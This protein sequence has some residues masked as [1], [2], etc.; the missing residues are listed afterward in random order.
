MLLSPPNMPFCLLFPIVLLS[1]LHL[2]LLESYFYP[3]YQQP[4]ACA[5]RNLLKF[6]FSLIGYFLRY[7]L[8]YNYDPLIT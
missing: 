4:V 6:S 3:H 1:F 8:I 2:V 5:S 7:F